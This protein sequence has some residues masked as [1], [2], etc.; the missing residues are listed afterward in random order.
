MTEG[1]AEPQETGINPASEAEPSAAEQAIA[2]D[3]QRT[4]AELG[5]TVEQLA[6]R[7]HVGAR[8]RHAAEDLPGRAAHAVAEVPAQVRRHAAAG[9]QHLRQ[10]TDAMPDTLGDRARAVAAGARRYRARLAA[11][12]AVL[13]LLA[14]AARRRRR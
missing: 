12:A 6:S 5:E 1:R 11:A 2:E 14:V 10:V 9:G 7:A 8:A 3:I 4:R 13:A